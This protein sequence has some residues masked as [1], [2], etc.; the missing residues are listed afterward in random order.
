MSKQRNRPIASDAGAVLRCVLIPTL[1]FALIL[2][3]LVLPAVVVASHEHKVT[4]LMRTGERVTGL[5]EDVE[6]GVAYVRVSEHVQRKMN[7]AD[8]A[9]LDFVGGASGLPETELVVAR[10]PE[11]LVLLRD[12][13]SWTGQ[14]VDVRG[15]EATATS[16]ETHSLYFRMAN[17]EERHIGLDVASRLYLGNFPA[18]TTIPSR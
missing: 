13:S 14:F 1:A 16:G 9:L 11:H 5:L 17:G 4:V 2:A 3:V 6:G 10:L 8:V 7:L 15:G 18:G 12:G